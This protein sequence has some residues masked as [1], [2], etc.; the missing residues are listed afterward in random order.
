MK[1]T[2][3]CIISVISLLFKYQFSLGQAPNLR[4]TKEFA[5]FTSVGAFINNGISKIYG[6]VGTNNG[7]YTGDSLTIIGNV[8][9]VNANSLQASIDLDSVYNE[10]SSLTCDSTI[11]TPLGNNR[12]LG[13]GIVYCMTTAVTLTG[14]LYLD[15]KSNPGSIFIIRIDG[16]LSTSTNSN[17]IMLNGGTPCNVFWQV[18][19][20]FNLG[21]NATFKGTVLINGAINLLKGA[22]LDGRAL[23]K[24]GAVELDNHLM[25][26]CDKNGA[27][28]P[29]KLLSFYAKPVGTY[30]QLNWSTATEVNNDYFTLEHSKN[31][32]TFEQVAQIKGAGNSSMIINYTTNDFNSYL[33]NS[34]Y[35]LRQT[36]FDGN[37]TYSDIILAKGGRDFTFNV[38]PN[39]F[40]Q[41]VNIYLENELFLNEAEFVVFDVLGKEF[42]RIPLKHSSTQLNTLEYKPGVYFYHILNNLTIIQSGRLVSQQ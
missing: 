26:G 23:S 34:F 5:L 40:Q 41:K 38:F 33:G 20:A 9:V 19:G 13:P 29:I 25:V 15:A 7:A 12:V 3:L 27:P 28:L 14:N 6:D 42:T 24:S 32:T 39:P 2:L 4:S 21:K 22:Y 1:T 31:G 35:R 8:H 17:V 18:N 36:D 16:A 30:F 10:V 37:Y 11:G